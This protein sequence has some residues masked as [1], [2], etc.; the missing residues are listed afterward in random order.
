[1][2]TRNPLQSTVHIWYG[3][4]ESTANADARCEV[5]IVQPD[6]AWARGENVTVQGYPLSF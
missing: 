5:E 2:N 1:M 6:G 4:D 3:C